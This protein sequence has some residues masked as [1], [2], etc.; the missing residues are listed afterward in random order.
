MSNIEK[1]DKWF[2]KYHYNEYIKYW[3]EFNKH[4]LNKGR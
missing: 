2:Y 1:F 3:N 4:N